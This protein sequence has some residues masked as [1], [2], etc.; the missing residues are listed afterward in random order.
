MSGWGSLSLQ[1]VKYLVEHTIEVL[2]DFVVPNADD[3][4]A[5]SR[6]HRISPG[7]PQLMPWP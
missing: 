3:P 5:I 7:V 2:V 6:Q 4:E 1:F